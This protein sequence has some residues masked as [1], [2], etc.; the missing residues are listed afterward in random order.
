MINEIDILHESHSRDFTCHTGKKAAGLL[1]VVSYHHKIF[2]ELGEYSFDSFTEPLVGPGRRMPVFLIQPIRNF[3]R[4]VGCLKEI[5]LNLG[6]EVP[7]VSKHRAIIIFPAHIIKITEVMDACGSHVI[8]MYDTAYSADGMELIPIVV[9]ALRCAI[10]P[11]WC[12]I[13][14]VTSH[15][16]AFRPCVLADLYRLGINAEYIL[17]TIY[18]DSHL[19]ADFFCKTS[20]QFTPDIELFSADQVWQILLA[21]MAQAMKKEILA[22]ESESLGCYTQ[23]HYFEVGKLRDNATTGYVSEFIHT[24]SGEILADSENSEEICHEVAHK[25]CDST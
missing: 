4:D 5:L 9:Y 20:R 3:K 13:D 16:T 10:S 24:I 8:R 15:D 11:V 6:T 19:L 18:C 12:H 22:V 1:C 14:I 25:Q 21:L 17:R 2:V 7:L 23:S